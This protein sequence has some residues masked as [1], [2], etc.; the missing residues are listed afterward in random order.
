M[1][2]M[3]ILVAA[4]TENE[5]KWANYA[6][7]LLSSHTGHDSEEIITCIDQNMDSSPRYL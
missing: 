1:V 6:C 5:Y 2:F 7:D 3:E 4:S